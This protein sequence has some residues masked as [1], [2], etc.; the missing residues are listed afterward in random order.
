[1]IEAETPFLS[2]KGRINFQPL[3][4]YG[5]YGEQCDRIEFET[6]FDFLRFNSGLISS[7][8]AG[9]TSLPLILASSPNPARKHQVSAISCRYRQLVEVG[10]LD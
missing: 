5:K 10:L 2:I 7:T 8:A 3:E 4:R 6:P 1:M 9:I